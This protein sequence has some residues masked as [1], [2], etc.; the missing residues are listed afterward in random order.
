M[1][2]E[3]L[4]QNFANYADQLSGLHSS[5]QAG[6]APDALPGFRETILFDHFAHAFDLPNGE[7]GLLFQI[8]EENETDI[9]L[10]EQIRVRAETMQ[11]ALGHRTLEQI[12]AY[13]D[14]DMA[15]IVAERYSKY[16]LGEVDDFALQSISRREY[17]RLFETFTTMQHL[18]L[19]PIGEYTASIKY[20][21]ITV[22]NMD[23]EHSLVVTI[24]E[25]GPHSSFADHVL[26]LGRNLAHHL[27]P[28]DSVPQFAIQYYLAC[29][30]LLGKDLSRELID[31]WLRRGLSI[32]R[33][34]Y[35]AQ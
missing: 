35:N 32:P 13:S 18:G 21:E 25:K 23:E 26:G 19:Q 17:A 6:A 20:P 12:V 29:D 5:I 11:M 34:D 33:I 30:K 1:S 15:A 14:R 24:Y 7:V 9:S 28:G 22:D 31:R 27:A 8:D 4:E 3:A 16:S 2:L 10:P